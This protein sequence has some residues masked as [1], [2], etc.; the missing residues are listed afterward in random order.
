MKAAQ[1]PHAK[2]NSDY[3]ATNILNYK[4]QMG[5]TTGIE[6]VI[7]ARKDLG[8]GKWMVQPYMI[9]ALE[10][11]V[12]LSFE[13]YGVVIIGMDINGHFNNQNEFIN[14]RDFASIQI[15]QKLNYTQLSIKLAE[16]LL[17]FNCYELRPKTTY[18]S[19]NVNHIQIIIDKYQK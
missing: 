19:D 1:F 6:T 4:H 10:Q 16:Q 2:I 15:K 11:R 14:Q 13:P 18:Q 8:V 17:V 5:L 9:G 3:D 12:V 7:A